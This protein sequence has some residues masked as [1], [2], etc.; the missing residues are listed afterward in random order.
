M[1]ESR[2]TL[3]ART[4]QGTLHLQVTLDDQIHWQGDVTAEPVTISMVLDDAVEMDHQ[5]A[6]TLG[7]K[8]PEDTVIDAQG[9]ILEDKTLEISHITIDDI[10]IQSL[11]HKHAE[12]AHDFN[13]TAEPVIDGFAGTMGCNGTVSLRFS[14]PVYLWL[15]ANM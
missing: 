1:T 9:Q 5:L 13:G 8:T 4:N 11:I 14:T 6:I 12:Y 3:Q 10:D 15:L 2:I 7:G